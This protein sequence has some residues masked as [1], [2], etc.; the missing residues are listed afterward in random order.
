MYTV[1][2]AKFRSY[3]HEKRAKLNCTNEQPP[4]RGSAVPNPVWVGLEWLLA[5]PRVPVIPDTPLIQT[6]FSPCSPLYERSLFEIGLSSFPLLMSGNVHPNPCPIFPCLVC[7]GN[8]TWRSRLVCNAAHALIGFI[9]SA[10]DSPFLDSELLAALTHGA[11][12]PLRPCFFWRFHTYQHCDF[13]L[14]LVY[15]NCSIWPPSAN[16]ALAFNPFSAHFASSPSA[17]SP[18]PDAP[19]CFSL[20]LASSS[21]H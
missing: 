20:P 8:V 5:F 10:H 13:L 4:Q 1:V 14:Q 18:P 7:A 3:I 16:A 11:P 12:P 15:L 2:S 17:P 19:G 21:P 6:I 9:Q